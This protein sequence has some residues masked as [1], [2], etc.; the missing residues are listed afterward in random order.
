MDL[1]KMDKQDLVYLFAMIGMAIAGV[2]ALLKTANVLNNAINDFYYLNEP[3]IIAFVELHP[4]LTAILVTYCFINALAFS[5]VFVA[6]FMS[7]CGSD[8]P[9][10]NLI[11][12][13]FFWLPL[14]FYYLLNFNLR[15]CCRCKEKKPIYV[16]YKNG[17]QFCY[18][19][20]RARFKEPHTCSTCGEKKLLYS[21]HDDGTKECEECYK[22]HESE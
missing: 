7:M 6:D 2:I 21:F 16:R 11:L 9:F 4:Y 19:C 14:I 3:P 20:W 5:F 1:I 17:Q 18:E 15:K 12:W 13:T 22:S 10:K 8:N